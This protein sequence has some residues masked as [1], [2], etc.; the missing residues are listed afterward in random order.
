MFL[1]YACHKRFKVYQM[2]V[3]STFLNGDLSEEFYMEQPKGF[4]FSDNSDLVCKVKKAL[5]GLKQAPRA[6]YHRLDT[7][8]KDKGFKRAIVNNNM[9]IKTEDNNFL[10]VLVYVDDTIF[11]CNKDSLVQWFS[12]AMESEFEMSMIGELSFF[13]VCK[14]LRGTK[15][16][17]FL[18]KNI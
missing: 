2:D 13:L 11:G 17:S 4:K 3:K 14:L 9:Y 6:W 12:S 8:L 7:Y 10:I 18:K 1:A 5:Y 15:G 16:C